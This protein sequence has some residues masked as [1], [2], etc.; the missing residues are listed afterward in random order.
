MTENGAVALVAAEGDALEAERVAR[1]RLERDHRGVDAY[2]AL[3]R[4]LLRLRR[5]DE[6]VRTC[7]QGLALD[8]SNKELQELLREARLLVLNDLMAS[9]SEDA[10]DVDEGATDNQSDGPIGAA[11]EGTASPRA[12]SVA[13][14]VTS[15]L[16]FEDKVDH[17]LRHLDLAKLFRLAALYILQELLQL[18]H[19]SLGLLLLALGLLAQAVVHRHKFMT[20]CIVLVCLNR[21]RL[22]GL[23]ERYVRRWVE[24]STDKLRAVVWLPR[25]IV[26]LPVAMKVFGLLKFI[27]FLRSDPWLWG[28]VTAVTASIVAASL[29][30]PSD[31]KAG[32]WGHG[33][34]LKFVAYS[35][36]VLYW[37]VWRGN[38]ADS[39]RL[40]APAL[41]DGGGIVLSSVTPDEIHAV[42]RR[43]WSRL[44]QE[45]LAGVQQDVELDALFVLG[46]TNWVIDYWQQPTDFSLEM[47]AKMLS[48]GVSSLQQSAAHVFRPELERL[49]RQMR[50]RMGRS[51]DEL[52][53]LVAYLKQSLRAVP[54]PKPLALFGLFSKRCPSFVVAILLV[55][56]FGTLPPPLLPFLASEASDAT[57]L[58]E[59]HTSGALEPLDGL[60]VLL[61]GSP[62]LRVWGNLKAAVHCLQGGVTIAKAVTT[63]TQILSTAVRLNHLARFAARVRHG[64]LSAHAHEIPDHVASAIAVVQD[65]S[66]IANGVRYVMETAHVEELR[67][68]LSRWW[69]GATPGGS[70][71]ATAGEGK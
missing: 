53:L 57:A 2:I 33:K 34:R 69:F 22:R 56:F 61:L 48:D 49:S 21:S 68:S 23:A 36:T 20:A 35:T 5:G 64:G 67:Q 17:I 62:L 14:P 3:S 42:C 10:D 70:E 32:R 43:A 26:A 9:D 58:Y 40:L 19:V 4:A 15:A 71:E 30:V 11:F 45:V 52:A 63:S 16:A 44:C 38:Y 59:L 41:L 25:A 29:L 12:T 37:A 8:A 50:E 47:L 13:P 18:R 1:C 28:I 55:V 46:L 51:D 6:A 39:L 65:S 66:V 24:T 31:E 7:K 54:P 60:D 27:L